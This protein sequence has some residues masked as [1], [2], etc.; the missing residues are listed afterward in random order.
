[1][2]VVDSHSLE[3]ILPPQC[4]Q[5]ISYFPIISN[6]KSKKIQERG[7][8]FP[9]YNPRQ[10]MPPQI[11]ICGDEI[12]EPLE[13]S[14]TEEYVHKVQNIFP[15]YY[16]YTS[17]TREELYKYGTQFKLKAQPCSIIWSITLE[18]SFEKNLT[19]GGIIRVI[20]PSGEDMFMDTSEITQKI[21]LTAQQP[22]ITLQGG[23]IDV[24]VYGL[25]ESD[26]MFNNVSVNLYVYYKA[27]NF[28]QEESNGF[29]ITNMTGRE[30]M[31]IHGV[32]PDQI[33]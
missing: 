22:D 26:I 23:Y 18:L 29:F 28:T 16:A 24:I 30:L 5:I 13:T 8:R 19:H 6:P 33:K 10:R 27:T 3:G 25:H 1:M 21:S 4:T 7:N 32:N 9:G 14:H 20:W 11:A 12:I 2:S 15:T 31:I 17:S